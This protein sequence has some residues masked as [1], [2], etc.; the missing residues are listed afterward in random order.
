MSKFCIE[1]ITMGFA[2]PEPKSVFYGHFSTDEE[3]VNWG[4]EKYKGWD[5]FDE[6]QIFFQKNLGAKV[7]EAYIQDCEDED[8]IHYSA[9]AKSNIISV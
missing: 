3:A 4:R 5:E 6:G 8:F 9:Y 1:E 2:Y 7:I